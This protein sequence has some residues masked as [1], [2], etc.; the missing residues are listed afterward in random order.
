MF[1]FEFL[2]SEESPISDM[3][4][5][6]I[7]GLGRAD[8]DLKDPQF[9]SN[10]ARS[11]FKRSHPLNGSVDMSTDFF[12]KDLKRGGFETYHCKTNARREMRS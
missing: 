6:S 10:K 2:C 4:F 8:Y 7:R 3:V 1:F 9:W 11:I 12:G 5:M